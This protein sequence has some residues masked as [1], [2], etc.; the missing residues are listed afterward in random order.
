MAA[1]LVLVSCKAPGFRRWG[2]ETA[3]CL[4]GARPGEASVECAGTADVEE[5][6]FVTQKHYQVE[7]ET[8]DA[9]ELLLEPTRY[10]IRD[11]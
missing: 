5:F 7:L 6:L 8:W 2:I 9:G 3:Q 10:A 1:A 4:P 11:F